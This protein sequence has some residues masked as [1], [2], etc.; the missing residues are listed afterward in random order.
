MLVLISDLSRKL[1][2]ER[3]ENRVLRSASACD[4]ALRPAMT[5]VD[6]MARNIG[7]LI[8]VILKAVSR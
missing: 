7:T 6:T 8:V 3:R 2:L 4:C 5:S 1:V